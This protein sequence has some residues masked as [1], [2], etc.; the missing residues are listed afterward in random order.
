MN[1]T[2]AVRHALP[3]QAHASRA[4]T[5]LAA[6]QLRRGTLIVGTVCAGMSAVVV[7]QYQS[8]FSG[9]LNQGALR[10]LA[11]NPAI[12]V[13]FGAPV[14]LDDPGGFTVW[15]TGTPVLMLAGVWIMLA[16]IRIT[17]GE[18]DSG[19]WDL[20]LS[21]QIRRVDVVGRYQLAL[22]GAVLLIAGG[23]SVGMIVA[24][25]DVHGA[26]I[27]GAGIFGVVMTFAALGLLSAQLMP[28]R[29]SAAGLATGFLGFALLIRML[30]DGV[31]ALAWS[32]W[33]SPLG[34]IARA[35]PYAENRISP[36]LVLA[37]YPVVLVVGSVVAAWH[38]DLGTG[39][40]SVSPR[41]ST[42]R[43]GLLGS[44]SG[45]AVRRAVRPTV[46][47][48][49]AVGIYFVIIGALIAS[50]LEFFDKNPRF[51]ELAAAAGF[52]G[53]NSAEGFV[54]ALFSLMT[55]ATG[56]FAVT[57]LATF[58]NHETERR[59][60][61]SFA[62]PFS[63][64]RLLSTEIAVAAVGLVSIHIAAAVATW[65]GAA[66]TGGP[67]RVD[68]ALAGALNTAPVA[69][70]ALG[71]A[72]LAVGWL[73]SAVSAVGALPVVGGF[74]LNVIAESMHA[75]TWVLNMSP[76]V[77]VAAVPS[78][79]PNVPATATF[80]VIGAAFMAVGTA[81]YRRRDLAS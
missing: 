10:A 68:G 54:A 56:L 36:L 50:M 7:V 70:L 45:F 42:H 78:V 35:A 2:V 31:P 79:S 34:L 20:L 58:V 14:A 26:L 23:T 47:W 57:R 81:G 16:A 67:L 28:S 1:A 41:R 55:V 43:I 60:T 25:T 22:A 46:A 69:W 64:E 40:L 61:M 72:A 13:L 4:I 48:A 62:S 8:T 77:H 49:V 18:E 65:S 71:A 51:A 33:L 27:Y 73:P 44:L 30:S 80:L 15:R 32:A 29:S 37:A 39:L 12:R 5:R 17:R 38:R 63:R 66:L 53:L 11:E 24:G 59:W 9:E 74:L 52:G 21:G 6:R 75:P 3:R 76:Y 19:R